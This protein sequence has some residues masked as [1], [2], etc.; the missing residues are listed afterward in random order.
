M[1]DVPPYRR[2]ADVLRA[3][4]GAGELLPGEP[5]PSARRI[6]RDHGVALATATKVLAVLRDDGLVRA[7]P[8]VGTVV[9]DRPD[10]APRPPRPTAAAQPARAAPELRTEQVVAAGIRLADED[11][12]AGV[13]MRR[14]A[15]ELGVATMSLYPRVRGKEELLVLMLDAVFAESPPPTPA[16][17]AS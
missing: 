6:A 16:P 11:G 4:I 10:R 13:S 8:G 17:G 5:I 9:V 2:I 12:L 14:I 3:R 1:P 15:A 7:V